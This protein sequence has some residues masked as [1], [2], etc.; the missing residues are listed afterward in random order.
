MQ[1]LALPKHKIGGLFMHKLHNG[2]QITVH[3]DHVALLAGAPLT[4]VPRADINGTVL[5]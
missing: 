1:L 4:I 3:M 2:L 5:D